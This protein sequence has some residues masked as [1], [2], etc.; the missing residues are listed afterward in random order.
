MSRQRGDEA[1]CPPSGE[2]DVV[3]S[4]GDTV[5]AAAAAVDRVEELDQKGD[6]SAEGKV[7]EVSACS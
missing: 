6:G 3:A 4:G 2:A 5:V 1:H 7:E